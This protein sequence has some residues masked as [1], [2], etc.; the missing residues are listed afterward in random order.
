MA[1]RIGE[2]AVVIGAGMAGLTAARAVADFFDRVL[3]LERDS[4]PTEPAHRAGIPQGRHV[5]M[6]LAGGERAL[7][8]LFPGFAGDLKD[9]GAVR[10]QAGVDLRAER[11]GFNPFPQRDL[12]FHNHGMSRSALEFAVRRRVAGGANVAIE[13][14]CRV[15]E[16]ATTDGRVTGVRRVTERG[17]RNMVAADLV[18][19]ASGRGDLTLALLRSLGRPLPEEET[20]GVDLA[21]GTSIFQIPSDA[22]RDWKGVFTFPHPPTSGR[23]AL[24]LPIEGG[25]WIVTVAGR[26]GDDPPGDPE[27]FLEYARGLA[28]PTIHD[29]IRHAKRLGDVAR[30]RFPESVY[31]HY[32]RLETL[33]AGVLP[34]GDAVCRFNPVY[35]QGMSVASQEAVLLRRVLGDVSAHSVP[36][37]RLVPAFF[38]ETPAL[39][40]TPWASAV[41]PDFVHPKTR[42]TRPDNFE[43][44]LKFGAALSRLAARDP[45]VHRMTAEVQN[46]MRPR[47]AYRD[48]ALVERVLAIMQ[49]PS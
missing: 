32:E 14:Q 36:L 11:P 33:P 3:V 9:I 49:E 19:E 35:G 39:L 18:I 2:R 38:A 20:I 15:E 25:R 37:D 17:E 13:H 5:H 44:L 10:L 31:R 34:I 12:G 41:I 30:F 24:L 47:S 7:D 46:L 42:G 28:T 23:A 26:H 29:T 27:G 43:M 48:P 8:T 40:E 45:E 21:Y 6:L 1:T 16:I 4:L 22:P